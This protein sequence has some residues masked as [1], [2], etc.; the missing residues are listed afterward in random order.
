MSSTATGR[1]PPT[2]FQRFRD[3]GVMTFATPMGMFDRDFP[4]HYLRLI[5]GVRTS[6]V[7]L[8]PPIQGI[9]ATLSTAGVS[10]V[11]I[12]PDIFQT[13]PIRRDPELVALTSPMNASGVF[14][15]EAQSSGMLL[16]FEGSG[17]DTTWELRMPKAANF[18]DYRTIGDVLITI[19]YTAL[20]SWDYAQQV[21]QSLRQS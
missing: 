14:E 9:H 20:Q 7:A 11:V 5:K 6:V 13:V 21:I 19:D 8:I 12:G 1:T 10:R 2:E 18:F 3:M 15:L 4:G 16:P 17:V